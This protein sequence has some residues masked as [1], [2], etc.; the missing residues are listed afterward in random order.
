MVV[1]DRRKN[2]DNT[3]HGV[4]GDLSYFNSTSFQYNLFVFF[5]FVFP[6][7]VSFYDLLQIYFVF[8]FIFCTVFSFSSSTTSILPFL[9]FVAYVKLFDV[10]CCM[11]GM[12]FFFSQQ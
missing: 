12:F 3:A 5:F 1:K 7:I 4:Y 10:V 11:N 6:Y 8:I 2:I 9:P